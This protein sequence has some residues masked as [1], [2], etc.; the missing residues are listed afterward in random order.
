MR[1]RAVASL[2]EASAAVQITTVVPSGNR[3][4]ASLA[5]DATPATSV[6]L[7]APISTGVPSGEEA[8]AAMSG[9]ASSSG[10]I[11]SRTVISCSAV[12][13][14]PAASVAVHVSVVVPSG[15][16]GGASLSSEAGPARSVAAG[17]SNRLP[18][19]TG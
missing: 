7:G 15:S 14:L 6:A 3:E 16:T 17:S 4:G 9:G 11:V 5:T 19:P 8:S 10:G 13:A 18:G 12:A 1:C 2:P